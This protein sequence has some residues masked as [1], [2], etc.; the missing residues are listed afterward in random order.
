MGA[1]AVS[2]AAS[3][4]AIGALIVGGA[5]GSLGLARGLGRRGIPVCFVSD[6]HRI[7]KY[8]R[9]VGRAFDWPGPTDESALAF[10]LGLASRHHLDGWVLIAAS[11]SM[12]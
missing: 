5:H 2:D 7:A 3:D 8:S 12:N 4:R 6:D 11:C 10:L 1:Q 9:Y